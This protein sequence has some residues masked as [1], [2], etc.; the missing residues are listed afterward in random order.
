VNPP[1]PARRPTAGYRTLH[2]LKA[3]RWVHVGAV[4]SPVAMND[5]TAISNELRAAG[6]NKVDILGWDFAFNTNQDG[7]DLMHKAGLDAR[8]LVIPREVLEKKAV[9]QGDIKFFELGALGVALTP[10]PPLPTSRE[11]GSTVTVTLTDFIVRLDD[12]PEEARKSITHWSQMLDYWAID[13]DYRGDAFHNQWQ[14]YRTRKEPKL[15]LSATH[16]YA[17]PGTY[18]IMVKAIDLLGNDTTKVL[19]VTV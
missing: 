2:G 17:E 10:R 14:S 4:D 11:R 18:R 8:F 5:L 7:K 1:K 15:T 12:I 6:G 3:G 19:E 9:E 13:W 16:E